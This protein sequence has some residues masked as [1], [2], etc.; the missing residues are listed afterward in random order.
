[1]PI[2]SLTKPL[3]GLFRREKCGWIGIDVG[4]A[5]LKIAQV[6]SRAGELVIAASALVENPHSADWASG[7]QD[8]SWIGRAIREDFLEFYRLK[9]AP[10][11][12]VL[13]PA[14]TEVRAIELPA[15]T[16]DELRAMAEEELK[17]SFPE[18]ADDLQFDLWDAPVPGTDPAAGTATFSALVTSRGLTERVAAEIASC[19]LDCRVLDGQPWTASR[20]A[21]LLLQTE[22]R[23]STIAILDWGHLTAQLIVMRQGQPLFA[24]AM[25]DCGLGGVVSSISQHLNI[26]AADVPHLLSVYGL[27]GAGTEVNGQQRLRQLLGDLLADSLKKL[28]DEL[29]KTLQ[30]LKL[31]WAA[32]APEYLVLIGG[33]A[34][35]RN[36]EVHLSES[37]EMSVE[38][39]RLPGASP[40]GEQFGQVPPPMLANAVALSILA[41]SS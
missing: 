11:A 17:T 5:S 14:V 29:A 33:G 6:E 15:G 7:A 19:G 21:Q 25:R 37:L 23:Q 1:M 32:Q 16:D 18:R 24:R 4:S 40:A 41:W 31:Q 30:Y 2:L 3:T 35:I 20:A 38:T 26:P 12:C 13:S 27:P 36:I 39:W 10:A 9:T 8:L 34:A 22:R 28:V